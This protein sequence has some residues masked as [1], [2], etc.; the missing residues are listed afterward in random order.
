MPE[1]RDKFNIA[2]FVLSTLDDFD[3]NIIDFKL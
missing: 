3:T 1:N 2:D